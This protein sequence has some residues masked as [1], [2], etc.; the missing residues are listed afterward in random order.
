MFGA[1]FSYRG[2]VEG[3]NEWKA[4][5]GREGTDRGGKKMN[6][7]RGVPGPNNRLGVKGEER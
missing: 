5:E 6:N 2:C 7:G 1:G 3:G 4:G